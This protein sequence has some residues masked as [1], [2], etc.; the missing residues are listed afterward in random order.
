PDDMPVLI[1]EVVIWEKEFRCFILDRQVRALSV[2]LRRG[3]L[4][5]DAGFAHTDEEVVEA[6]RFLQCGPADPR[7]ELARAGALDIS[8]IEGRGWA[9][10]EQNAA[11]GSG[12]YGCDPEEVLHVLRHAAAPAAS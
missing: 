6:R 9:V 2:Y 12:L 4:Q 10:V 7:G 3:V 5:R 8:C 11:W 1:A